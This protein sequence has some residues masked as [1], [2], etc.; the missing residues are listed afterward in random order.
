MHREISL[1]KI[2]VSNYTETIVDTDLL[3]IQVHNNNNSLVFVNGL[4][5]L[6][7]FGGLP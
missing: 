5:H 7:S 6:M 2:N 3:G 1:L 4:M